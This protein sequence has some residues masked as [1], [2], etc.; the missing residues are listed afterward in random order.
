MNLFKYIFVA[1]FFTAALSISSFAQSTGSIAGTVTDVNGGVVQGATVTA[2]GGDG[3]EKTATSNK[4][5]EFTVTGLPAGNY[6]LRVIAPNFAL[7]ENPEVA[8]AAGK[9]A[10]LNVTLTVQAVAANVEVGNPDQVSADDPTKN[11]DATVLKD[12][13]LEALPDDPDDLAAALQAL[14]GP[15]A[16]PNGG[17]I[18][19]DGFTGGNLPPKEA[20]REIRINSNPFSAEF[21]RLGFGRIEILTKPGSDKYHGNAFFNFN[22]ES[23]NSRNP[24]AINRAP[25]QTRFFGG[26]F[27]GPIQ[28][29]KSSFFID[30]NK[31]DQDNNAI[32]NA[33]VLDPALNPVQF[34]QEVVVPNRRFS[35]APRVDYAINDKNTLVARY[36]YNN[37]SADNQGVGDTSLPQRGYKTSSVGHEIRLTETM[38]INPKTVNETRFGYEFNDRRST[39]LTTAPTVNVSTFF[40]AGGASVG[41]SFTKSNNWELSNN[42][43][44][45]FGKNS[46]HSVKFGIRLRGV[47][48][49]DQSEN[50]FAGNFSFSGIAQRTVPAG[51]TP[52]GPNDPACRIIASVGPLVQYQNEVLGTVNPDYNYNPTQYSINAGDPLQSV[53]QVDFGGFFTDDWRL[54]PGLTLSLG[55]RYENQTNIH[56]N[57]NFAPRL[58]L[59][60]SPGAGGAKAP[61]TVFRTGF[62][63]FYDRFSENYTLNAERFNGVNQINYVVSSLDPVPARRAAAL[64]LLAQPVFNSDGSVSNV[65][66]IAQIQALLPGASTVRQIQNDLTVPYTMQ[67]AFSVERQLPWRTTFSASYIASRTLHALRTR[68]LNAPICPAQQGCLGAPVPFPQ[69][70][71][72]YEYESGG[73]INQNQLILNFRS[74]F[75]PRISLFGNYRLGFSKGNT[76]GAGTFPAYTYDLSGEYGR[77]SGDIRN[78]FTVGGNITLPHGFSLSPFIIASS[79]RPF[80]IIEGV[81][82]NGDILL[83]ERPTFAE[84][85]ARCAFLQLTASWCNVSG[86]DPNA[87]LPRNWGEGPGSFTTNLRISKNFGFGGK[88]E[89]TVAGNQQGGGN[90]GGNRGGGNRGGGGGGNRGGGGGF[91]GPGGGGGPMMMGGGFGGGD[92]RKPYNLNLSINIQNLF[93]NVNLGTPVGNLNSFRFG[94]STSTGGGFGGFG[95]GGGGTANRRI[96]LSARFSW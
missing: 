11:A 42:T 32:V 24:F 15:S 55:L 13:D 37:T 86:Q 3:K 78:M 91:G 74:N 27:S 72:I 58:A 79:G 47:H 10:E 92:R 22:D 16:G 68:N 62:G 73:V 2:V 56:S 14:A 6:I 77:S 17:Q 44:T 23:L 5:G 87:I 66:T 67:A 57:V 36:E 63:V 54:R 51:C 70:N 76:D 60:W 20:I 89:A 53:S 46:Q 82:N 64:L 9:K 18:Y 71:G 61:K 52:T 19:I 94:Q 81:D 7:F 69:F 59:A 40:T 85:G 25:S 45:A 65:P 88:H 48:I 83:T 50:N 35:F 26:N 28:K 33:I 80:N 41:Q 4:T 96:D 43:T 29:G 95:G 75:S 21:D 1:I 31:R 38:I 49:N 93:N 30:I 12:K 39:A 84:L 90:G 8:V 34:S